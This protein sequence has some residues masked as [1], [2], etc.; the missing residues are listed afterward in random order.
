MFVT[1]RHNIEHNLFTRFSP[2]TQQQLN[3]LVLK[4][5]FAENMKCYINQ[6]PWKGNCWDVP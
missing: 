1:W 6:W 5:T 3:P 4:I 2:S